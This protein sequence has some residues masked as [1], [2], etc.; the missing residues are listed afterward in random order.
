MSTP[1][2]H[3]SSANPFTPAEWEQFHADD[4]HAAKLIIGLMGAI[5]SIGLVLYFSICMM[6][7]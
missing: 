3:G 6:I 4:R 5:F 1:H 7:S 2:G